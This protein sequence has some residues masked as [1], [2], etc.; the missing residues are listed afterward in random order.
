MQ[1]KE[2]YQTLSQRKPANLELKLYPNYVLRVRRHGEHGVKREKVTC[3][4]RR[5][6]AEV[7]EPRSSPV[8][9]ATFPRSFFSPGVIVVNDCDCFSGL[10]ISPCL[11]ISIKVF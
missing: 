9:M 5:E 10:A 7:R 2:P 3:C 1:F 6:C 8:F 11:V 4:Y